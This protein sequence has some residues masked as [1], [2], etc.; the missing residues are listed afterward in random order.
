MIGNRE[1]KPLNIEELSE[2][3]RAVA[4]ELMAAVYAFNASGDGADERARL[5]FLTGMTLAWLVR[6]ADERGL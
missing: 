2:N 3:P 4:R 1:P 6:V 5:M